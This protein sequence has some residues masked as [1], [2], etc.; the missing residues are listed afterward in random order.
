MCVSLMHKE[1]TD[2]TWPSV[3][4][5]VGA[6]GS[7]IHVPIMEVEGDIASS[8]RQVKPHVASLGGGEGGGDV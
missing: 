6:P 5:L 1:A 4:V 8:M 3:E 7:H 2:G